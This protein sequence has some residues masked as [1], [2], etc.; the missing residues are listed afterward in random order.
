MSANNKQVGGSHYQSALQ[1]WD[2]ITDNGF[3]Y[4][5]GCATKYLTRYRLKNGREDLH[6]AQ[7]YVEKLRELIGQGVELPTHN[8][9]QIALEEFLDANMVPTI[10]HPPFYWIL[11]GKTHA[12][13]TAA[14]RHIEML[15]D[16]YKPAALKLV[17]KKKR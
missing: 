15:V 2:F 6:K 7:H 11:Y 16:E 13:L 8:P 10:D 14:C 1:H 17:K 5:R 4:I 12:E 9:N 3:S